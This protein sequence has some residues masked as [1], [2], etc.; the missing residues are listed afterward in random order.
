MSSARL[1]SAFVAT[2]L[3]ILVSPASAQEILT[4]MRIAGLDGD[5]THELHKGEIV[6]TGYSQTIGTRNCSRACTV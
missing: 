2:A 1:M 4:H 5:S 6:L 3:L